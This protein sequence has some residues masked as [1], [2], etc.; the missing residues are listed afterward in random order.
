MYPAGMGH[1]HCPRCGGNDSY[2]GNTLVNRKGV[3]LTQ[4]IGDSGVYGSASSGGTET[5]QVRK[6]RKCGEILTSSNYIKDEFER[7]RDSVESKKDE[8]R[9]IVG[10]ALVLFS[11]FAT[12]VG[13]CWMLYN[14]K[15]GTF[16]DWLDWASVIA[17]GTTITFLAWL[18]F[19]AIFAFAWPRR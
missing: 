7:Q 6:C 9:T 11:I 4:E 13:V 15:K 3:T 1:Y 12:W 2:V 18:L 8:K 5:I 10:I 17:Q 16:Y 19:G 14:E